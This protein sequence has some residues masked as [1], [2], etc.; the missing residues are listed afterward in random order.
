[1]LL[2]NALAT[3]TIAA[4]VPDPAPSLVTVAPRS[5][6]RGVALIAH[7]GRSKST[8]PDSNM[9]TP[10][11]RMFPFLADL[12]RAGR[13]GGLAVAQLRYRMIGY[14]DGD[15]VRDLEWAL[16]ELSGRFGAPVCLVGHSMGAR[17]ALRAAGHDSVQAVAGL[18][19]WCPPE[20]PVSQL[21][22]RTVMLVHGSR[23]RITDPAG[24]LHLGR[25]ARGTAARI[26]RFEV[27]GAGHA[28][29]E[30]LPLWQWLTRRFVLGA[31]GLEP[32]DERIAGAFALPSERALRVP[33]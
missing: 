28:M 24:S 22:G 14:N 29:L 13:R 32:M 19:A 21:A 8:A 17:A 7:G 16:N 9:R 23:D 33:L 12:A 15:P 6:A 27:A 31:L 3:G 5:P 10:A 25:R 30:R 4:P 26:A 1:M 20:E 18:A 2:V 11:L